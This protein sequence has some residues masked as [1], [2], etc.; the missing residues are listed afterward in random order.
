M[1]FKK[2]NTLCTVPLSMHLLLER[3]NRQ[4]FSFIVSHIKSHHLF[5]Y[6]QMMFARTFAYIL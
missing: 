5:P 3:A 4:A 1:L 2:G 6:K